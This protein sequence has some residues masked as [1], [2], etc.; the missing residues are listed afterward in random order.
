MERG[1]RPEGCEF[2]IMS[3]DGKGELTVWTRPAGEQICRGFFGC[4]ERQLAL[5]ILDGKYDGGYQAPL[6]RG[7]EQVKS[8]KGQVTRDSGWPEWIGASAELKPE[9]PSC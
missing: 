4:S 9:V 8:D 3:R 1:T 7:K 6:L 2:Y 5:D